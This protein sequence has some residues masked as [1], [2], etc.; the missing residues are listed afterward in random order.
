MPVTGRAC[1]PAA[2]GRRGQAGRPAQSGGHG[3][4]QGTH[5][6]VSDPASS[7]AGVTDQPFGAFAP[8]EYQHLIRGDADTLLGALA[9][10]DP[11]ARVPACPEWTISDLVEHLGRTHQWARL[12]AV[13]GLDSTS[14]RHPTEGPDG[15]T[16]ATWYRQAV[17]ELLQA[18]AGTDPGTPCWTFQ[19][20]NGVAGFWS[21]R[22]SHETAMHRND[23]VAATGGD[24]RYDA[25]H[26]VGGLGEVLDVFLKRRKTYG[27]PP[28]DVPAPVLI[29]CTDRPERWLVTPVAGDPES[30]TATGPE[31]AE[32]SAAAAAVRGPAA[33]LLLAMWKR[34][35]PEAAGLTLEGD[36]EL[37][38]GLFAAKLTP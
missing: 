13:S 16:L 22:Q 21:R 1:P 31:L 7:I 27:V 3:V 38:G 20:D 34:Q 14:P 11:A 17:D 12:N 8:E 19:H 23:L 4:L 2:G 37:G 6:R 29:E 24:Y 36:T 18:L 5:Q 25:A 9:D 35:S 30:H 26:A 15:A 32:T 28:R 10:A 33:G